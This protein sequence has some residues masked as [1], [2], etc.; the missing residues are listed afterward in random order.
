MNDTKEDFADVVLSAEGRYRRTAILRMARRESRLRVRRQFGRRAGV[1]GACLSIG[2]AIFWLTRPRNEAALQI[3]HQSPLTQ[4]MPQPA[5]RVT[6]Q[7]PKATPLEIRITRI[8]TDRM[9]VERLTV[10]PQ[11]PSWT[12]IDDDEL[13]R[14]LAEAGRPAGL[15]YVDG[16]TLILF[17][18]AK[19]R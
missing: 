15:A 18:G 13:L 6:V 7:R 14:R 3:V 11:K 1:T 16:R 17:R 2:I 8:E 4:P 5:T 19:V 12:V 10:P 9:L